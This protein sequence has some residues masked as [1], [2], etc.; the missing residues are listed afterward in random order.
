V[1]AGKKKVGVHPYGKPKKLMPEKGKAVHLLLNQ[2]FKTGRYIYSSRPV[3][4]ILLCQ[5]CLEWEF[6]QEKG[7]TRACERTGLAYSLL[8]KGIISSK[9]ETI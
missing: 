4:L 2:E 3:L 1:V 5:Q 7:R 8:T 9:R 6:S